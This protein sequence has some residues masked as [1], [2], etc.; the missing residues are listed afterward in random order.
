ML[1]T[2]CFAAQRTSAASR[3]N[4]FPFSIMLGCWPRRSRVGTDE[5]LRRELARSR[6]IAQ[7]ESGERIDAT[8]RAVAA[9]CH[10]AIGCRQQSSG[11]IARVLNGGWPWMLRRQP[12]VDGEDLDFCF[13]GNPSAPAVV[14]TQITEQPQPAMQVNQCWPSLGPGPIPACGDASRRRVAHREQLRARRTLRGRCLRCRSLRVDI[15]GH[16]IALHSIRGTTS[17]EVTRRAGC[18]NHR[19]QSSARRGGATG[20]LDHMEALPASRRIEAGTPA[21]CVVR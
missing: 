16:L 13:E 11:D 7:R 4:P 3:P 17:P 2:H 18:A 10:R 19:Q 20:S 21:R 14:R 9:D 1:G 5:N 15:K 12:A 6:L 8:A